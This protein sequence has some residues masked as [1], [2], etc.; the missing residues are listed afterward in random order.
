M[1]NTNTF[2][3]QTKKSKFLGI[4]DS[5]AS[6]YILNGDFKDLTNLSKKEYCDKLVILTSDI[7][8]NN[9][10]QTSLEFLDQRTKNGIVV[11]THTKDDI[12]FIN[13]DTMFKLDVQNNI[14]KRRMCI[15]ISKFYIKIAH[16]YAALLMTLNP[17][18]QYK[19]ASGILRSVPFMSKNIIPAN[20]RTSAKL[21][22]MNMCSRRINSL[23][24]EPE[25]IRDVCGNM[26]DTGYTKISNTF[27]DLNREPTLNMKNDGSTRKLINEIGLSELNRLYYDIFDYDKGIYSEMS[28]ESKRE[29]KEDL[30]I[31]YKA[32]TGNK[33]IPSNIKSFSDVTLK[34]FHKH[35]SCG[36]NSILNRKIKVDN[37]NKYLILLGEALNKSVNETNKIRD[38]FILL[39]DEL[40]IERVDNVTKNK[41][42]IIHPKLTIEKLD[43]MVSIARHEIGNLYIKCERD[44]INIL[45]IY[46]ALLEDRIKKSIDKRIEKIK[47]L[48]EKTIVDK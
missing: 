16:L 41:E 12:A 42:I 21:K 44:F 1:G 34:G 22:K 48:T 15:G 47:E 2:P 27:C 10:D 3:K 30:Q 26:I 5:I 32:F 4:M 8:R 19:D 11:N 25:T 13:R 6:K 7:F 20:I 18:Y 24:F 39:L 28:D 9:F 29:Y 23:L 38:S 35:A 31:F 45:K 17:T 36:E 33:D 37:N 40:F 46:E 43:N 14:K